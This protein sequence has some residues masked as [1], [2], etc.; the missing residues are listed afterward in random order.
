MVEEELYQQALSL[1]R[2]GKK[3]QA[4]QI[5]KQVIT[6]NPHHENAWIWFIDSLGAENAQIKALELW[7]KVDPQNITARQ[8]MSG[9]LKRKRE[10]E[11]EPIPGVV[12][13]IEEPVKSEEKTSIS[14][15]PITVEPQKP[16]EVD[17]SQVQSITPPDLTIREVKSAKRG[18]KRLITYLIVGFL[19]ILA[20]GATAVYFGLKYLDSQGIVS[21]PFGTGCNCAT[22]DAYLVRVKDRV[23]TWRTNQSLLT[24]AGLLGTSPASIDTAYQLFNEELSEDVP[25]CLKQTH[26]IFLGLIDLQIKY[27]ES[28]RDG[29]QSQA[30]YYLTSLQ[31]KQEELQQEFSRVSQELICTP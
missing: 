31:I 6:A 26:E 15:K 9:F 4:R 12:Q 7:Q 11:A 18:N 28:L 30:D 16:D 10:L 17:L 29:N 25:N 22:T 14:Q 23:E 5:L 24:L 1:I 3:G 8:G 20:L 13:V 19:I 27:G 21:L 2:E